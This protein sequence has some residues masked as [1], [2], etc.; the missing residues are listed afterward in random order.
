M[1]DVPDINAQIAHARD[2]LDMRE[3]N[4]PR[5]V[6]RGVLSQEAAD[7]ELS[8]ARAILA[9]LEAWKAARS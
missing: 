1:S 9:T 2:A 5:L 7:R 3:R 8:V 4:L 6:G